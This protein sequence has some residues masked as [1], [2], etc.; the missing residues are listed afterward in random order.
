MFLGLELPQ[1]LWCP[2]GSSVLRTPSP[3]PTFLW[4]CP[5]AALCLLGQLFLLS[6]LFVFWIFHARFHYYLPIFN[7]SFIQ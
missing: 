3:H 5:W 1:A 4:G 2:G 6:L 7:S